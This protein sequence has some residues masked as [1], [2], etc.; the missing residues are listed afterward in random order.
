[1]RS[2]TLCALTV[3]NLSTK[4]RDSSSLIEE[5]GDCVDSRNEI[6]EQCNNVI[7]YLTICDE[8]YRFTLIPALSIGRLWR[9][10]R[11]CEAQPW[12]VLRMNDCYI[13]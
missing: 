11:R 7:A 2:V 1:M 5:Y 3:Y 10:Q 12:R 9:R 13:P 8:R 6:N 4:P